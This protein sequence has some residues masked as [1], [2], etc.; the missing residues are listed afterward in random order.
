MIVYFTG[1]DDGGILLSTTLL[2]TTFASSIVHQVGT[3][4]DEIIRYRVGVVEFYY[5]GGWRMLRDV[6]FIF[7]FFFLFF[8]RFCCQMSTLGIDFFLLSV[9]RPPT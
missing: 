8:A 7:Y 6:L 4:V 2:F 3:L 5:L 9:G 1:D